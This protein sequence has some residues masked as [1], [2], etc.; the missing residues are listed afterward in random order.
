MTDLLLIAALQIV[1]IA[2]AVEILYRKMPQGLITKAFDNCQRM[3]GSIS[4]RREKTELKARSRIRSDLWA[5]F[6]GVAIVGN[7]FVGFVHTMVI[8]LPIGLRALA[9][10]D[11]NHEQFVA[12]LK[13]S[14]VIADDATSRK[15]RL[16]SREN[17]EA[18][19]RLLWNVWP[20]VLCV[21]I[22]WFLASCY[23][24]AFAHRKSLEE[25]A[26]GLKRRS[27]EYLMR[28]LSRIPS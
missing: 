24:L 19:Q 28:D 12:N 4:H 7:L 9:A 5:A 1:L 11:P 22:L 6:L 15:A 13:N 14:N 25:Y 18:S 8:E 20:I 21:A 17:T 16:G 26:S 2:I 10:F 3:D 23:A 27:K